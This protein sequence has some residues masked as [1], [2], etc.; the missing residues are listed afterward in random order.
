[1]AVAAP[2]AQMQRGGRARALG[3]EGQPGHD[4]MHTSL[5]GLELEEIVVVTARTL[6]SWVLV[7]IKVAILAFY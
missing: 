1:M 7:C 4:P 5:T 3:R 6:K 2:A